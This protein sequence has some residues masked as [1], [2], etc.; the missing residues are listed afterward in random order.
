[1]RNSGRLLIVAALAVAG[2]SAFWGDVV[3]AVPALAPYR[4][5]I[6]AIGIISFFGGLGLILFSYFGQIAKYL[7]ERLFGHW[8]YD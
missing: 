8:V 5:L 4:G 2:M 1:M 6:V 7:K 3:A